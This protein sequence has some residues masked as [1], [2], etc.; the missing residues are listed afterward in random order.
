MHHGLDL[1]IT[2]RPFDRR[3]VADIPL[4]DAIGKRRLAMPTR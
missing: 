2:Q 1:V 4:N 3:A